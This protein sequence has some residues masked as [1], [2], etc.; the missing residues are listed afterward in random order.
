MQGMFM[1]F[2]DISS[3]TILTLL[4]SRDT[5]ASQSVKH[6][7]ETINPY[8]TIVHSEL[9]AL[10]TNNTG[11]ESISD[12]DLHDP[13]I[14]LLAVCM[15]LFAQ[16]DGS[17]KSI[18]EEGVERPIYRAA[19]QILSIL[20]TLNTP[21]I[22][23]IQCSLLLAFYEYS[24]GDLG[25]AYV[26]IGDANTMALILRVGPGKYLEAEWDAYVPYE[27]EESRCL[28]WSLFVLD[29]LIQT[30]YSLL[31]M[32]HQIPPPIVSPPLADDLLPT[33]HLLRFDD[34]K[35]PYYVTQRYPA[36]TAFSV[37]VGIFQRNCQCAMLYNR[38][39]FPQSAYKSASPT[40]NPLSSRQYDSILKWSSS[41]SP[42]LFG[43]H[44][45]TWEPD[46]VEVFSP[47]GEG[48]ATPDTISDI[49][50][51][52]LLFQKDIDDLV[53]QNETEAA[54]TAFKKSGHVG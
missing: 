42:L 44:L 34:D 41:F 8:L 11:Y 17:V 39:S 6:Y 16:Q 30:D 43:T 1:P 20:R 51:S 13:S 32:P 5:A 24:H 26:S 52:L 10:R 38:T 7:M 27:E 21:S 36:N 18:S 22:E 23:L 15:H 19:K 47:Y 12:Q 37:P 48:I 31:H 2:L 50:E 35:S 14:A 29:C 28:Y 3:S 33:N 9:F 45:S 54:R 25:R 40:A 49:T 4:S 53:L 46:G